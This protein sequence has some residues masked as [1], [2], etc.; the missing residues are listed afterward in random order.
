MIPR[1]FLF[2]GAVLALLPALPLQVA[3]AQEMPGVTA[4]EIKV[5]STFPFSGPASALGNVGKGLMVYV[6]HIN[7]TGGINGRKIKLIAL[8]DAY[9]PGKSV[10]Q[11]RKLVE[12]DGVAFIFSPLGTAAI[13]ANLKYMNTNKV[14]QLFVVTGGDKFTDYATYPYTTTAMP[15]YN[16][17][18]KVYAKFINEKLPK[19]RIAILYQNDDMGK[20]LVGG[21]RSFLKDDYDKRVVAKAYEVTD[22]TIDS[23]IVT[24]KSSGAEAFFFAGSPKFGAQTIRKIREIGW[25]PL[26]VINVAASSVASALTPAGLDNSKGITTSTFL[27][28]PTDPTW[29]D[30]P[31]VKNYR[32]ILAKY[33]PVADPSEG[34]YL[35]GFAQGEIL[36]KLLEQCGNDLS[37]ENI[38][39][40]ALNIKNFSP[41]LA[42]RGLKINTSPT[43]NQAYL[44]LQLQEFNGR[45]WVPFGGV[46]S[47]A[48]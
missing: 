40:Q 35:Y 38:M 2:A 31:A 41:T 11:N 16:T 46:V 48:D 20:D 36:K 21:V 27:K 5:G 45:S 8:D 3:N 33:L 18:G 37:R 22:P 28:D 44:G 1:N 32:T 14:P 34:F 30:D 4:T 12:S 17:E 29:T 39:K 23:Q 42:A 43:N 19:A 24:L 9:T 26:M 7:D 6:D 15:S 13:S 25:N 47:A 10:E